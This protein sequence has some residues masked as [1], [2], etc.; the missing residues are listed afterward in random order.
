MAGSPASTRVGALALAAALHAC[1]GSGADESPPTG[2]D[3]PYRDEWRLE[4]SAP[5]PYDPESADPGIERVII[6]ERYPELGS[7]NRGDVIVK[8]DAPSETIEVELRRFTFVGSLEEATLAFER[9]GVIA[10]DAD[11]H[12]CT[13]RWWDRCTLTQAYD[14][15]LQPLRDGADMRVHLPAD[16]HHRVEVEAHDV[17]D[18][19]DYPDRGNV[20]LEAF[21]G[22]ADIELDSGLVFVALSDATTAS[23]L[24]SPDEVAACETNGWDTCGC[25]FGRF[26]AENRDVQR[27]DM[28]LDL[29]PGLWASI[30]LTNVDTQGELC[31]LSIDVP[32]VVLGTTTQQRV[33]GEVARPDGVADGAT[34]YDVEMR[35]IQCAQAQFA[36]GPEDF[37]QAGSELRGNLRVCS[38]C[39]GGR[40]CEELLEGR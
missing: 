31:E 14:G 18:E 39:L 3:R 23:P 24:C 8:F 4:F 12:D 25:A 15:Q 2:E 40:S 36:S 30:S 20:C 13:Q 37:E 22:E 35:S 1:G 29:P 7:P 9:L 17:S 38:G 10:V 19:S 32:G 28:T 26:R 21:A 34:G 33:E 5:F 27:S 11:G 6:G 16:Y